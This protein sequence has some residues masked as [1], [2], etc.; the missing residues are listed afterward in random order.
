MVPSPH[1][2]QGHPELLAGPAA[3]SRVLLLQRS[4][5]WDKSST[6]A[7]FV[8]GSSFLLPP[9]NLLSPGE[10]GS[11]LFSVSSP[12][13]KRFPQ[14]RNLLSSEPLAIVD[15]EAV[16]NQTWLLCSV[17]VGSSRSGHLKTPCCTL[18]ALVPSGLD[19]EQRF[20]NLRTGACQMISLHRV[21]TD[22]GGGLQ[23]EGGS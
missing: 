15:S 20:Q 11:E 9:L 3:A 10:A 6:P 13:F 8:P 23:T 4:T 21:Q 19:P 22:G 7:A 12:L 14:N 2:C 5:S 16:C 1:L 17:R 18:H